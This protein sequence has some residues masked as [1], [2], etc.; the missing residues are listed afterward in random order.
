MVFT[1]LGVFF[2]LCGKYT[3][4]TG[5][6]FIDELD[7][8]LGAW[9]IYF[10]WCFSFIF[11]IFLFIIC[12]LLL[13]VGVLTS[14]ICVVI[15]D[16]PNDFEGYLGSRLPGASLQGA[17]PH[18]ILDGCFQNKSLFTLLNMT[19][20]FSFKDALNFDGSDNF[21]ASSAFSFSRFD[22]MH[23]TVHSLTYNNFSSPNS[24]IDEDI[25]QAEAYN[26][27]SLA[28][29]LKV[30]KNNSITTVTWMKRDIDVIKLKINLLQN[31]SDEFKSGLSS[32]KP[33]AL[34]I[35]DAATS[36]ADNGYCGFIKTQYNNLG[37]AL[38]GS[39]LES[40]LRLSLYCFLAGLFGLPM[41]YANLEIN[42]RFGGHGEYKE[43]E[44]DDSF[45]DFGPVR[46]LTFQKMKT[47]VFGDKNNDKVVPYEEQREQ[48]DVVVEKYVVQT[49]DEDEDD[50]V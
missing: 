47:S 34:Q 48:Q 49:K 50:F 30:V 24:T 38:C 41:I 12:A 33:Y 9:L 45:A 43:G 14:D 15:D 11:I 8:R 16:M 4:C 17:A 42:R 25:A 13:P 6:K 32:I 29:E 10:A 22:D 2:E 36:I 46:G 27:T 39:F 19:G 40:L 26:Q 23:T 37:R 3:N 28:N 7:D 18:T 44:E 20:A 31:S 35:V 1:A 21:N 5:C